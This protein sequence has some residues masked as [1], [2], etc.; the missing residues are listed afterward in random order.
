[1]TSNILNENSIIIPSFVEIIFHNVDGKKSLT[2]VPLTNP[3]LNTDSSQNL[4]KI[5]SDQKNN[6]NNFENNLNTAELKRRIRSK[7]DTLTE[8][9]GVLNITISTLSRN[10][11]KPSRRFMRRL[12]KAGIDI[13]INQI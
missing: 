2:I 8:C 11:D 10:L 3:N 9:A 7:F 13:P 4:L 12:I 5:I 1:M 6:E